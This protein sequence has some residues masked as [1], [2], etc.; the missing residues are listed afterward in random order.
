M[1]LSGHSH[2]GRTE[3]LP[4]D[5]PPQLGGAAE[6]FEVALLWETIEHVSFITVFF[7]RCYTLKDVGCGW[8]AWQV[9]FFCVQRKHKLEQRLNCPLALEASRL[10]LTA[11]QRSQPLGRSQLIASLQQTGRFSKQYNYRYTSIIITTPHI[12]VQGKQSVEIT[13]RSLRISLHILSLVFSMLHS[14]NGQHAKSV[15]FAICIA[16]FSKLT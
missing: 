10:T 4:P 5:S 6:L 2:R 13:L 11:C 14:A 12:L 15:V 7:S 8:N 1:L 3:S 16:P 9:R